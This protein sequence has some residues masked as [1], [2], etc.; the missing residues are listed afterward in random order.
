MTRKYAYLI[1]YTLDA[2]AEEII[3]LNVKH[4]AQKQN[5]PTPDLHALDPQLS[6][7][8]STSESCASATSSSARRKPEGSIRGNGA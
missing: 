1:Y 2:D 4:P 5:I 7:A 6:A 3:I 8:A